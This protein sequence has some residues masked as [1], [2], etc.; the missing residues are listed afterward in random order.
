SL[1]APHATLLPYTTLFRSQKPAAGS[2]N[3]NSTYPF[4]L[5]QFFDFTTWHT[6]S[7]LLRSLVTNNNWPGAKLEFNRMIAP[8]PKTM[9]VLVRSKEH[10]S[11]LQSHLNLVC[12]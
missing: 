3:S 6:T 9:T 1:T 7:F 8:E 4:T 5:R 10:T 11:E 2:V 12:R